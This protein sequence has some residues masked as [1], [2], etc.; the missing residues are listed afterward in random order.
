LSG[1][2]GHFLKIG[3]LLSNTSAVIHEFLK[4]VGQGFDVDTP[5]GTYLVLK[6]IVP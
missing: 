3:F 2:G 5:N 6:K 4:P 1:F